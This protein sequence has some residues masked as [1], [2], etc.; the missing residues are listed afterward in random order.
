MQFY[1]FL[2]E[3]GNLIRFSEMKED[4]FQKALAILVDGV[5]EFLVDHN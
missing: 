5:R 4:S 3:D 2:G 1:L